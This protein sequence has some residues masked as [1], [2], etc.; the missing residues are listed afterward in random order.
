MC[1]AH[2][3]LTKM[4]MTNSVKMVQEGILTSSLA[5]FCRFGRSR[6]DTSGRSLVSGK[7]FGYL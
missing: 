2:F 5:S 4:K 6:R 7:I 3:P 1:H